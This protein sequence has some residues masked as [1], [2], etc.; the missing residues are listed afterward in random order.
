[1]S[2]VLR[3]SAVYAAALTASLITAFIY[4]KNLPYPNS[5][6]LPLG[7]ALFFLCDINVGLYNIVSADNNIFWILIW[8]CYLPSQTL[9]ALSAKK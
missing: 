6:I 5:L 2:L 8:V 4:R 1:M 3:L 7:M 9:L